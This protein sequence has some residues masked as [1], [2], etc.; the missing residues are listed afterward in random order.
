MAGKALTQG[1]DSTSNFSQVWSD[2]KQNALEPA[3]KYMEKH[4]SVALYMYTWNMLQPGNGDAAGKTEQPKETIESD[5]LYYF[6]SEAIQ[7]LKHSQV[8]CINAK[9]RTKALLNLNTSN[10]HVRFSTFV[11]SYDQWTFTENASCF[12]VYTC[13]GADIT[14]Y[15]ALKQSKQV[16][17]P[18]YEVFTV[19]RIQT[20]T[21]RCGVTYRL[22][23]N[24]NCVYDKESNSLHPISALSVERFFLIFAIICI[25]IVSPLLPFLIV[26]AL[27]YHKKNI[28]Y[29]ASSL[30]RRTY[31]PTE[32]VI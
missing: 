13:F 17:I 2:A 22:K 19:N 25:I 30:H 31:N 20:D 28:M 18:P 24:L 29:R 14:L 9:Y 8:T 4:H 21:Q 1:W 32:V 7:I 6:L 12:D 5:S 26:K 11:L 16:L 23:S 3:H 27:K 10:T 15:S